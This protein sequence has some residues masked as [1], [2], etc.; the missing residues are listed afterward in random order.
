MGDRE[1]LAEGLLARQL[2]RRAL[3]KAGAA[4]PLGAGM[5][6][7]A[8][9]GTAFAQEVPDLTG[10]T[11]RVWAGGTTGGPAEQAAVEFGE[12]TGAEVLVERVPF[13]ERAL[14]FAGLIAGQDGSV[15]ILTNNGQYAGQFGD[16]LYEN[17]SDPQW[18]IDT[19]PFVPATITILTSDGGLRALPLYSEILLYIYNKTMFDA[20]GLDPENPPDN[21]PELYASAEALTEGDRFPAQVPWQVSYGSAAF[22]IPFL[23]SIEGARLLSDDRTQVLFGGDDGLLAFQ[24]VEDGIKAGF[25]DPNLAPDIEDYAI[26]TNFNNARTASQTN[27]AELWGYAVGGDPENFPTILLPEEVGVTIMP[28]VTPGTSGSVN[29]FEGFG[30]NKFGTQKEAALAFI[31]YISGLEFQKAMTMAKTLPSSRSDVLNDPEVKAVYPIGEVLAEQA[32][33]NVDRYAAPYDWT[34]PVSDALGKLYR[35]EID[36]AQA[37][38]DAVAGVEEI[39]LTW[40]SS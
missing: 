11:L 33:W 40:L 30:L 10:T 17:L 28:G 38:A 22:F 29:G 26:G 20:A 3:L 23:N 24:T 15:D 31:Q 8:G 2:S 6:A 35:G 14:R 7:L 21:W 32:E 19:S 5:L 12:L 13:E 36:A 25:F 37:H 4:V 1:K 27:F 16:R 18:A 34:P 9:R 39:V